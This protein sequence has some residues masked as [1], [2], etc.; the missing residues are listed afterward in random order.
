MSVTRI[1]N[2]QITNSTVIASAKLVSG[3][4]TGGLLS[5]PLNYSGDFTISGNLTVNGTTTTVDTT[6]TL[7]ADP[8]IVLSRGEAGTPSNDAGILIERGTSDNSA[9][10]WDETN[11]RWMAITT[12]ANGQTG[13]TVSVAAY[14]NIKANDIEI[15]SIS[16]G[17][18][19]ISGNT[20]SST[21]SNGN[22]NISPNG[23]GEVI[24][25]TLA[26][27]DLTSNRV[28]YVGSNDALVDS[29]NLTF[30]GTT[31][32]ATATANVTGQL[33]VDNIRIDGSVISTFASNNNISLTPNGTGE[34]VAATL[35][36]SD[37][38]STRVTYAST[39]G[40]L[41]DNANLTFSGTLLTVT[42][43]ANVSNT[44]NIGNLQFSTNTI[45]ATNANGNITITPIGTGN[46]IINTAT[47]NRVF[48][49]GAN[50]EQITSAN[51]TFDGTNAAIGGDL[52]V[53]G[54][55]LT[56][57]A[58]GTAT[59]FNANATT[60]NV[61]GAATAMSIGAGTGTTT[62]NNNTNITLDLGV[63]GGDITSSATTFNLLNATVTTLNVG[64][65]A[66][67]VNIGAAT[68]TTIVKNN[69]DVDGNINMDGGN[70]T[71]SAATVNIANV[72]TTTLN[73][74]GAA[75][76]VNIGAATGTTIIKNS[77]DVD[78]DLNVDG[79]D[80]TMSGTTANIANATVT[81]VNF[82]RAATT[83]SIGASTGTTTVNN[84][85]TV[86]GNLVV[87]G[88]TTTVDSTTTTVVDPIFTIGGGAG[89]AAPSADDNKD[90]G[91]AFQWHTGSVAKVGFFGYDDSASAFTFVPDATIASEV[92]SGTAGNLILA[93]ANL[94]NIGINGNTISSLDTN[95]N[96]NVTPNGA[97]DINLSADTVVVGDS[98]T[99]ANLTTNG[100]GNLVLSTN[101]NATS[102]NI[103]I[104][105]GSN[106][107]IILTPNGTGNVVLGN[108]AIADNNLIST[109]TNANVN[110]IPNGTGDINLSADTVVVGDSATAATITTNGTGNLTLST[111]S[112]SNSGNI[113]IAQ[114]ANANIT[115]TSNGT[116]NVVIDNLA[117]NDA[118]LIST[119]TNANIT[120]IPN[121]T[122]D[123]VLS[124]DTVTIGDS[125]AAATLSTQGTGNL[126]LNTNG[127]SNSGIITIV[128]GT[129]ANI[130]ITPNG[131]GEVVA[132]TL[133]V[134]DLTSTRIT[135]ASANGALV[136]NANLT[137]SGTLL[138]VT[139]S[140]NI[141]TT[142]NIGNF[143][144]T[145]NTISSTNTNGNINLTPNGTGEVIAASLTVS[146]LTSTRV[147]LAGTSGSLTD[148]SNL[149]F[150]GTLLTVTGSANI[151]TTANIGNIQITGNSI[152]STNTNGNI[153]ITANGTGWVV[154]NNG[155]D[156]SDFIVNGNSSVSATYANL[157]Y[158]KASTGQIGIG[159]NSPAANVLIDM[160]AF[161]TSV[162]LPKGTTG[163]RP[164]GDE[165]EGMLRYNTSNHVYEFWDGDSW[166]STTGNFT[167]INADSFSG[168][169]TTL[170][171]TLSQD[172]TSAG[173][174]VSING[175]VQI[176]GTAYGVSG[177]TLTFTEAPQVG[178]EIDVR[179]LTTTT[180]VTDI[181][182][183]NTS[184]EVND[185]AER[186]NVIIDGD[187]IL[188]VTNV[189]VIP[190]ANN[191][192]TLGSVGNLW[193]TVYAQNTTV[194]NADLAENYLGDSPIAPATVVSFGGNEEVTI[195][196][197]DMDTRVAG[198]VS[199]NPAHVMN[200]FLEGEHVITVA[201]QGRVPCRVV[202]TVRKGD[203][204]VSAGNGMARAEAYPKYGSVIGKAIENFDGLE[205]VIE[206]VV[207]R[208]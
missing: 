151:S 182:D 6:N 2:N 115:I 4:V 30:D 193:S 27:T 122:G 75:T 80:I 94:G 19:D 103:T 49:A 50:K 72:T 24:A 76:A 98:N 199:T 104:V 106:G 116:G 149:T 25:A 68:G 56:T 5:D 105:Q 64:G 34:V 43:N 20:I 158:V 54:A 127:G 152:S 89:G 201:L 58:T 177:T 18:I 141:S 61:G 13:G 176:P 32:V 62:I 112:G 28:V 132:S 36:V 165:V 10:L 52:A 47:A 130:N 14:A 79:G 143:Q 124:A 168:D 100:T 147:V 198:V 102:S 186:A 189:S 29:S 90:R 92:V 166:E 37:L 48:Y 113:I 7:I 96:I 46:L 87:Q 73:I 63:N 42:G 44:A 74:G 38:T 140:A 178:D 108:L 101:L 3:S 134:S 119:Q 196:I 183:L 139:G 78:G 150:S 138:T 171:F 173:I 12:T 180:T 206:V 69:L 88:T 109:V 153:N 70:F 195:S 128:Q 204:M 117:I 39:N 148:N 11:D 85:M 179:I 15:T 8:V 118:T 194:Q 66:T 91:I 162:L 163:Q 174:I 137:F 1:K 33:N 95:G 125:G 60:L 203:M 81:T 35:A 23:S 53:N 17:N 142:A 184:I 51:F 77:L 164:S 192:I 131:T 207:G 110:I 187:L 154:V 57:T 172:A 84:N 155:A 200:S 167:V 197:V 41:V 21:N 157:F 123:V 160:D 22:I 107:N 59:L 126:T 202:G 120:L 191:T 121:G 185:S 161:T 175:V 82:A 114:G 86:A 65:A 111:N 136:D 190:G 26:V 170:A 16:M 93:G 181:T 97:G 31:L 99:A 208:V 133:A 156:S 9:W 146:D 55:D 45:T 159:T 188:S 169:S 144:I 40:S 135:Y 205:G 145:S 83:L 71:T 129:N 67:A